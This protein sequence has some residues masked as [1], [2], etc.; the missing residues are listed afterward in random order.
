MDAGTKKQ[1]FTSRR[2]VSKHSHWTGHA[3]VPPTTRREHRG[4][5]RWLIALIIL[6]PLEKLL[7]KI[8]LRKA[9]YFS[10]LKQ[11]SL[12]WS[13]WASQCNL[14]PCHY[15]LLQLWSCTLCSSLFSH[16]L[17]LSSVAFLVVCTVSLARSIDP[18][19]ARRAAST[20]FP[21]TQF[22]YRRRQPGVE[23]LP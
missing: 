5:F 6:K 11:R 23:S 15:A 4:S 9:C 21:P 7:R 13:P 2:L 8:I 3:I 22:V 18:S 10:T 1:S 16:Q 17:W 20:D 14:C 19:V 12:E